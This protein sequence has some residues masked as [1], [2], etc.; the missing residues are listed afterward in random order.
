MQLT[1]SFTNTQILLDKLNDN[2]SDLN[3]RR[4]IV[5]HF[6]SLRF[7]NRIVNGNMFHYEHRSL[8]LLQNCWVL[9]IKCSRLCKYVTFDL[10]K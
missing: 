1:N 9:F 8:Y 2:I 3:A 5:H 10:N 6:A 4:S 7:S